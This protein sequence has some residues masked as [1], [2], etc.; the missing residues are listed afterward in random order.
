MSLICLHGAG[1]SSNFWKLQ[2]EA[3][4]PRYPVLAV[5]LPG[6]GENSQPALETV[7][8]MAETSYASILKYKPHR[9]ILVGFSLGGAIAIQLL[10]DHPAFFSGAVLIATGAKLRVLPE[11][12]ELVRND[13]S[14][15]LEVKA[16]L[17]ISP[18]T[19]PELIRFVMDD[20]KKCDPIVVEKDFIACQQFDARERLKQ[21]VTPTLI[22]SAQ[23][24][25]LTPPRF[26]RFLAENIPRSTFHIIDRA[27]HFV[28]IERAA[29]VNQHISDFLH[30]L[31][32]DQ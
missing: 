13:Y 14:R 11:I 10:L 24:D 17:S 20:A 27:G 23:D 9:P 31:E 1:G 12:L 30:F 19:D 15:Y 7:E 29:R 28:C 26:G 16:H 32:R 5:D 6:H 25:Q 18:A 2:R 4:Q 8:K 22:I 3:F 21:I